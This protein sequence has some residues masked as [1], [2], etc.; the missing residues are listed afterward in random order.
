MTI[1]TWEDKQCKQSGRRSR[2]GSRRDMLSLTLGKSLD[3][4]PDSTRYHGVG[5]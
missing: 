2:L 3:V 1:C 5:S 4:S